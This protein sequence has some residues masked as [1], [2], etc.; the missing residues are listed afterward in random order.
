[1]SESW[2][3]LRQC[4]PWCW[5]H[6]SSDQVMHRSFPSTCP[7][8][9]K[10]SYLSTHYNTHIGSDSV[11]RTNAGLVFWNVS[12]EPR[13]ASICIAQIRQ[14]Y[15]GGNVH[16]SHSYKT[17]DV[18]LE[19]EEMG[20]TTRFYPFALSVASMKRS[21]QV[22]H[23]TCQCATADILPEYPCA[24]GEGCFA[25]LRISG[26]TSESVRNINMEHALRSS[27]WRL[28]KINPA[29]FSYITIFFYV[30][31]HQSAKIKS[32]TSGGVGYPRSRTRVRSRTAPCGRGS[33]TRVAERAW[34][35]SPERVQRASRHSATCVLRQRQQWWGL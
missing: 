2:P 7:I 31:S 13:T 20:T 27:I 9:S 23:L 30:K 11:D 1:M 25:R 6:P 4:F 29:D 14:S 18:M 22:T 15:S 5:K 19:A 21:R 3:P 26:I 33:K 32:N 28:I 16:Q 24:G 8:L 35:S 10:H 17:A 12:H 34:S